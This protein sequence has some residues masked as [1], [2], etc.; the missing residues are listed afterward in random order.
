MGLTN[1][2]DCSSSAIKLSDKRLFQINRRYNSS[3]INDNSKTVY[4]SPEKSCV[5]N[6][7]IELLILDT[8]RDKII[9]NKIELRVIKN[10]KGLSEIN[11]KNSLFLIGS[12]DDQQEHGS[13]NFRLTNVKPD[14]T[15]FEILINSQFS[16]ISP[17][18]C[19]IGDETILVV[20]GK[21]QTACESYDT[22]FSRWDVLPNLPE[23]R[24]HCTLVVDSAKKYVYLFGGFCKA[25]EKICGSVYRL[26][27]HK[28]LSWEK[29]TLGDKRTYELL[30]RSS[31]AG[32]TIPHHDY[33]Y[34]LGGKN[35]ETAETDQIIRFDPINFKAIE[36]SLKLKEPAKF[37]NQTGSFIS[38]TFFVFFNTR[39]DVEKV[40]LRDIK[41]LT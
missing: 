30:N 32:I 21:G 9:T 38:D 41:M 5:S 6:S 20:G 29:I 17:S 4:N 40:F 26:H 34:L 7:E 11:Y 16:H 31:C 33:I 39:N 37:I 35:A 22:E 36:L 25:K 12:D 3:N 19:Y 1:C 18:L 14:Q 15:N 23:E 13:Y 8:E 24:F 10:L 28:Q 2:N 27:I